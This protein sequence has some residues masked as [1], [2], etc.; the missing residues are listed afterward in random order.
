MIAIEFAKSSKDPFYIP[1]GK[2]KGTKIK[3]LTWMV[4]DNDQLIL[5]LEVGKLQYS[6]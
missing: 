5:L 2:M 6:P 1:A 3:T 4:L